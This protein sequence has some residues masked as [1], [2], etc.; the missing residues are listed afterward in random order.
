MT[1]HKF[2]KDFKEFAVRGSVVDMG[3]GV[4]VGTAFV[5][6]V[7]SLVSDIIM[8]PI[9]L[10]LGKVNFSNLYINLSGGHYRSLVEAKE[11]GAVTINYGVFIDSIIHFAIVAL[12]TYFTIVQ[13]NRIR[14]AP[15]ESLTT[16]ECP[17]CFRSIPTRAVR[18]PQCTTILNDEEKL[19]E[20]EGHKKVGDEHEKTPPITNTEH[21]RVKI[22]LKSS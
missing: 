5:K 6:I 3:I 9:G 11:A 16:K 1:I 17:Y 8:P 4:V 22:N 18:C 19:D 7:D 12:A 21:R 13:I 14:R 20:Q 10:V 15:A 2:L